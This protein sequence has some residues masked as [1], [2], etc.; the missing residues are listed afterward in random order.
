VEFAA[1]R[2]SLVGSTYGIRLSASGTFGPLDP[3]DLRETG[4]ALEI[5][6]AKGVTLVRSLIPGSAI[7]A[8]PAG[9]AFRI[10]KGAAIEELG[11]VRQLR[12]RMRRDGMMRLVARGVGSQLPESFPT[13]LTLRV[14]AG[15]QCGL[16]TCLAF[17][18]TSDCD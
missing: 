4:L 5:S 7:S 9:T 1:K 8:N 13:D 17:P 15:T 10:A 18:R 11:G 2:I 12:A 3:V 16:D 6:D 14:V